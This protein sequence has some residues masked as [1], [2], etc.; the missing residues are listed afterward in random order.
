MNGNFLLIYLPDAEPVVVD[1]GDSD[2][3]ELYTTEAEL[4]F[5][6][7]RAYANK[8]YLVFVSV[9][10][11]VPNRSFYRSRTEDY[12][13]G[14]HGNVDTRTT[15]E[16]VSDGVAAWLIGSRTAECRVARFRLYDP[17]D[18]GDVALLAD[19]L[20]SGTVHHV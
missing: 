4:F 19:R 12:L 8:G 15:F 2:I 16:V 5:R 10:K 17:K 13:A 3:E 11:R 1:F 20:A 7:V 6:Q 14:P 18:L 9:G